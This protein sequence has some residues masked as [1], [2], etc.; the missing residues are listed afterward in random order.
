MVDADLNVSFC[1]N[2][3]DTGLLILISSRIF[4]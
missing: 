3:E 4:S 2:V 1:T